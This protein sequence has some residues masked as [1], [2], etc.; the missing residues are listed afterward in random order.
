MCDLLA[1]E[2]QLT[3]TS[4]AALSRNITDWNT[5]PPKTN[6]RGEMGSCMPLYGCLVSTWW[7]VF[8]TQGRVS[9]LQME[10]WR[11]PFYVLL[12]VSTWE[13]KGFYTVPHC[14]KGKEMWA[15]TSNSSKLNFAKS[16]YIKNRFQWILNTSSRHASLVIIKFPPLNSAWLSKNQPHSDSTRL[17]LNEKFWTWYSCITCKPEIQNVDRAT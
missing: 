12:A 15:T 10:N 11:S 5:F 4:P 7:C 16:C 14:T 13:M 9:S 3:L 6:C 2:P 8:G 17:N 1:E